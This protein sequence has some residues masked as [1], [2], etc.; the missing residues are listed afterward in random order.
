MN[1]KQRRILGILLAIFALGS[2]VLAGCS[3][4]GTTTGTTTT[5]NGSGRGNCAN[6]TVHTLV[7][8][9]QEPCVNMTKNSKLQVDPV[10]NSLHIIHSDSWINVNL[11]LIT[12][13]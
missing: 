3:T 6:E 10:V 7:T 12:E 8:T 11:V 13:A 2:I 5:T 1:R 4:Q 9:F